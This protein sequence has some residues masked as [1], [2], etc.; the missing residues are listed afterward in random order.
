MKSLFSLICLGI[1]VAT[2]PSCGSK[3]D[4]TAPTNKTASFQVI[5]VLEKDFYDDAHIA[6]SINVPLMKVKEYAAPLD[7]N[8]E[9]VVYCANYPCSASAAA[10][11]DLTNMGFKNVW[12][13]EGG[14]AEWFQMGLPIQGQ[15]QQEYIRGPNERAEIDP[16]VRV[17]EAAEL[18]AKMQAA[19]I[20]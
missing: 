6:G 14:T 16:N 10:W 5:N 4:T 15:A 2:L 12:V 9:I 19:G 18:K 3:E 13:Y 7:R 20:L 11:R 17:I 1:L 8:T